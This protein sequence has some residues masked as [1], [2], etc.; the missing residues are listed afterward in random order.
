MARVLL[1]DEAKEDVKD[2][3]RSAQIKVLRKMKE[4]ETDPDQRGQPLGSKGGGNLTTF[5]KLIVGD[6]QYRIVYRIEPDETVVVVWVVAKRADD[7]CYQL[8]VSRLETY[9][10]PAMA[11]K[12]QLLIEQVW[13]ETALE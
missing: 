1:T 6:R 10:D 13:S 5:R 7:Y 9:K 11:D 4:L 2:L 12:L 8:A 3:D